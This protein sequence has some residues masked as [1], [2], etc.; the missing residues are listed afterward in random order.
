MKKLKTPL[1]FLLALFLCIPLCACSGD[2]RNDTYNSIN[3]F[4]A[5]SYRI[6]FRSGDKLCDFVTAALEVL[7]ADG[8]IRSLSYNWFNADLSVMQGNA[9]ALDELSEE[10]AARVFIM[11]LE[12]VATGMAVPDGAE[13][14]TGF[15]IELAEAV[16]SLLGWELRVQEI[17]V[18]NIAVELSSGNI[19]AVWG[20]ISPTPEEVSFSL[21]PAYLEFEYKLVVRSDSGI[22][23][24][25][26]LDENDVLGISSHGGEEAATAEQSWYKKLDGL[27]VR[28]SGPEA[29][30]K[31]LDDGRCDAAVMES[32]AFLSMTK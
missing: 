25:G 19:D 14:Y 4:G 2:R 15:D 28:Y 13:G 16:C 6:A 7:A 10:P 11:G 5:G 27:V 24:P 31:A 23:R 8:T 9:S 21:S 29:C 17:D 20:G 3:T 32:T 1:L 12:P 30:F 26:K 18:D 22:S